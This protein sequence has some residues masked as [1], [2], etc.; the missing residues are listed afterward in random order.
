VTGLSVE[1]LRTHRGSFKLGPVDLECPAGSATVILGS[2]GAGKSTL[3]RAVAGFLPLDGGR[4]TLDGT[5]L[6]E[7]P[8]ERRGLGF[9]PAG[10][11]LFPHRRVAE[12][13]GYALELQDREGRLG[14]TQRWMEHFGLTQLARRFPAQL[15]S[16]ERQRVALARA[17]AA[18][19][20]LLLWDEPLSAL[21]VELREELLHLLRD[22]LEE[23]RIPLL[24]VTH[25]PPTA[26]SLADRY[27]ELYG[28]SVRFTGSAEEFHRDPRD[29]FHARFLGFENVWTRAELESARA[30]SEL[31]EQLSALAGPGGVAVPASAFEVAVAGAPSGHPFTTERWQLTPTL[32]LVWGRSGSLR[33]RAQVSGSAPARLHGPVEVR[34]H[35]ERVRPLGTGGKGA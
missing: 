32:T 33:L 16:G 24:L 31:A 9:V 20:R 22:V 30:G 34:F 3:L 35:P 4:V 17:L 19:P 1:E 26:F 8:P 12:N 5:D 25:D 11:G 6:A 7:L 28:G 21:D 15:S 14:E 27:L 10:L 13:V 18:S 29:S 2:S 23:A